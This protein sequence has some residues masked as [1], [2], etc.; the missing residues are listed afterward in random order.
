MKAIRQAQNKKAPSDH[1]MS[2]RNANWG[3]T[4]E[5]TLAGA[6][7]PG[8]VIAVHPLAPT[9][10][11]WRWSALVDPDRH[12]CNTDVA[13]PRN[14]QFPLEYLSAL[15]QYPI[16]RLPASPLMKVK[17][18][19]RLLYCQPN[20]AY[21]RFY[22]GTDAAHQG[23]NTYAIPFGSPISRSGQTKLHLSSL[24]C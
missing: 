9:G 20:L 18:R 7:A 12:L 23:I 16:G 6:L 8:L 24:R 11:H 1:G 22:V 15:S 17:P 19:L 13:T 21:W 4:V 3:P 14:R 10:T 2:P 5:H